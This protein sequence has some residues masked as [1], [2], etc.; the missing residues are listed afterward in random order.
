MKKL[1]GNIMTPIKEEYII[2]AAIH[3]KDGE[4]YKHQPR[5]IAS[6]YVLCGRRHSDVIHAHFILCSK[7]THSETSVQG[8][9]TSRN[10]FLD[11]IEAG[12]LALSIGQVID[13]TEGDE[14][15]S[16]ELY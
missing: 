16:E 8:F 7:S 3:Y 6:G 2:C 4:K 15:I 13:F 11:R 1:N 5:N 10:N 12:R 14:L 9:L